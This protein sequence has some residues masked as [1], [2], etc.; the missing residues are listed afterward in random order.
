M[1]Q[2]ARPNAPVERL[3][4]GTAG[5]DDVLGGGLPADRLYLLEGDPGTGKTTL[6]MQFVLEGAGANENVLYMTLSEGRRE[7]AAAAASHGWSLDRVNIREYI[8]P[9]SSL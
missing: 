8:A 1:A 4:T 2:E 3:N 6:A 5:L 7:L 9:A